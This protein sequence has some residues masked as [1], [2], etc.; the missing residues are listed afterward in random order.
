MI[1]P[2]RTEPFKYEKFV[3]TCSTHLPSTSFKKSKARIVSWRD[4]TTKFTLRDLT[5]IWES[6]TMPN[7]DGSWPSVPIP[8]LVAACLWSPLLV[9]EN[10]KPKK[11]YICFDA[12]ELWWRRN[13]DRLTAKGL[14]FG[15]TAW[16][17]YLTDQPAGNRSPESWRSSQSSGRSSQP[18][19][20]Q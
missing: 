4:E 10:G 15:N 18:L 11:W 8:L 12:Y 2:V 1:C 9:R 3:S 19:D 17:A 5:R 6:A 7:K 16:P 20:S 13:R 14:K